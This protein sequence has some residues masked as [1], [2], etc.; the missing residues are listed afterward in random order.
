MRSLA[1]S[2]LEGGLQALEVCNAFKPISLSTTAV[3][4]PPTIAPTTYCNGVLK[5]D[6]VLLVDTLASPANDDKS[7]A[8]ERLRDALATGIPFG[9]GV[10][11][12]IVT[13]DSAG[14]QSAILSPDA[15]AFNAAW[16]AKL[17]SQSFTATATSIDVQPAYGVV[18]SMLTQQ[19]PLE[20]IL[21][22]DHPV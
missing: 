9:T 1:S 4:A 22:S 7:A 12:A 20:A 19:T 14:E 11:I 3:P 13:L 6:I 5:R 18:A 8:L 16:N 10:R 2:K 15:T 21:V 17:V